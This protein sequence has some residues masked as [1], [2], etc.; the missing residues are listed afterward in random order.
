MHFERLSASKFYLYYN[1]SFFS[2]VE[3]DFADL[4]YFNIC[5]Y[6]ANNIHVSS[7][8]KWL[9]SFD[10][11]SMY[12]ISIPHPYIDGVTQMINNTN[13]LYNVN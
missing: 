2:S 11:Y 3:S 9:D 1:G 10:L 7:F 6:N 5:A 13:H 4:V 8:L 12:P